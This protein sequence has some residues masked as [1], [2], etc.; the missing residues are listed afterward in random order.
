MAKEI[1]F[2][3]AASDMPTIAMAPASLVLQNQ[4]VVSMPVHRFIGSKEELIENITKLI[5]S[6]Y[7]ADDKVINATV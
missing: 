4:S 7:E 3:I 2:G 6:F 5:N 1:I